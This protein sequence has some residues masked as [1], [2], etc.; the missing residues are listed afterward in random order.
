M[1]NK[2]YILNI[3]LVLVVFL[4]S[5]NLPSGQNEQGAAMTAAAQTIEA[6]TSGQPSLGLTTPTFTS[7]PAGPPSS[8]PSS[9]QPPPTNTPIATATSNCNIAQFITDVTIPDNT[10]MTPNQAF[11]KTWRFKNVGTCSWTPSYAIVFSSGNSMN[12]P[13]TQ[14]LSGNINPG[15]TVDISVNLNAPG[16]TGDYTGYWRLRDASGLLFNQFYVQIKVQNP[17]TA[18]FTLPPA[19][20]FAV[21]SSPVTAS[22]ACGAFTA[23]ASI[24]TNGAGSV[25]YH[26]VR[27]DGASDV[28]IHPPVVFAAGGIPQTVSTTWSLSAVGTNWIDIYIDSPNHQQ[29]GRAT[30]TCP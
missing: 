30:F 4:A 27:S 5:C 14:A 20:V 16:S 15:Q 1:K 6:L 28:A 11:T 24:T 26:W 25:T 18:T 8:T 19:I 12:G 22:G 9:T 10:I 21:T 7:I 2:F 23:T 17:V 29:F 13:A 3:L